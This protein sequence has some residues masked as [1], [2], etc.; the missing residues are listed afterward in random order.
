M[1]ALKMESF[2]YNHSIDDFSTGINKTR[3]RDHVYVQEKV[4]NI[5]AKSR[6][7]IFRN[8]EIKGINALQ[9]F[10]LLA[11]SQVHKATSSIVE[12]A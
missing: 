6:P 10:T 11:F 4:I 7:T 2:L 3:Q 8:K 12:I 5:C 1:A 9:K